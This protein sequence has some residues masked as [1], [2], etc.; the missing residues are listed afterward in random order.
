MRLIYRFLPFF[1]AFLTQVV[2]AS[3][4]AVDKRVKSALAVAQ[5]YLEMGT[6]TYVYGG[7]DDDGLDCSHF[8]QKVFS[9]A[10]LEFPYINTALMLSLPPAK[11]RSR[12]RLVTLGRDMA[13]IRPG[14]F[15]VY[16]GHVVLVEAVK[17]LGV[18]DILHATGGRDIK[19]PGQGVQR[20]RAVKFEYFRGMLLLILRH[21][22]LS[23]VEK[24]R[25]I[26]R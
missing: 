7:A 19:G 24:L 2:L 25:R 10:G 12:Y 26:Q 21:E 20:E 17:G 9:E 15:L 14:D 22:K 3:D 16:K 5:K 8:I 1:V 11:L 18:G 13:L 23:R 6:I 4:D